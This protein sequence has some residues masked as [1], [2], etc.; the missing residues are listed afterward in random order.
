MTIAFNIIILVLAALSVAIIVW[1]CNKEIQ[2]VRN[3]KGRLLQVELDSEHL[4]AEIRMLSQTLKQIE[5]VLDNW[6]NDFS[7][8][9]KQ[10]N[11]PKLIIVGRTVG[12]Q[13]ERIEKSAKKA[14]ATEKKEDKQPAENKNT[15]SFAAAHRELY[16]KL[17]KQGLSIREAGVKAGV[18]HTTACRYEQWGKRNSDKLL[19]K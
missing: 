17:R 8:A 9:K 5:T 12:L 7:N 19:N 15:A 14:M 11:T 3:F 6:E 1:S 10:P 2:Y 16:F 13:K 4:K 18:S